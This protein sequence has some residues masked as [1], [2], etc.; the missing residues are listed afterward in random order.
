MVD[1]TVL[2]LSDKLFLDIKLTHTFMPN[3]IHKLWMVSNKQIFNLRVC[4][5]SLVNW[6]FTKTTL[7]KFVKWQKSRSVCCNFTEKFELHNFWQKNDKKQSERKSWE[8]TVCLG[9]KGQF[10]IHLPT[11]PFQRSYLMFLLHNC[12]L[13][14]I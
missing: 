4:Y 10:L 8:L 1:L 2:I 12:F 6:L 7:K 11:S 14:R 9:E 13:W 5:G 3:M